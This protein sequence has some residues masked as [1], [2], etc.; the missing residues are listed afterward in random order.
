MD[1]FLN[2]SFVTVYNMFYYYWALYNQFIVKC[3]YLLSSKNKVP[4]MY[5]KKMVYA[6]IY[7]S[8]GQMLNIRTGI[9]VV[10]AIRRAN[11][12]SILIFYGH[13]YSVSRR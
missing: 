9:P 2:P 4:N 11:F 8:W 5:R 10:P 13:M 3:T 1:G 6:L 7:L 12:S